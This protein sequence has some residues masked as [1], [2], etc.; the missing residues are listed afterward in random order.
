[1]SYS[2]NSS[3]TEVTVT[4]TVDELFNKVYR[5]TSYIARNIRDDKGNHELQGIVLSPEDRDMFGDLLD[6]EAA[7]CYEPFLQF[8]KPV[9]DYYS[10]ST[11]LTFHIFLPP[12]YNS[13]MLPIVANNLEQA[14][15]NGVV[16]RWFKLVGGNRLGNAY[17]QVTEDAT[18]SY[19]K[20]KELYMFLLYR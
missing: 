20:L 12:R 10:I 4:F 15:V 9:E 1:M 3:E 19:N 2:V 14:L 16:L 13:E 7:H 17:Q 8:G 6:N 11:S 18:N 5:A